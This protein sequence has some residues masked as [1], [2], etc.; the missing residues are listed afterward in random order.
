MT[1]E[2]CTR[3]DDIYIYGHNTNPTASKHVKH[4]FAQMK[5]STKKYI[6]PKKIKNTT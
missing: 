6:F 3:G 2:S 4:A 1:T 5:R